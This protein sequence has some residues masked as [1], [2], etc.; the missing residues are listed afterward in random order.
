MLHALNVKFK[1]ETALKLGFGKFLVPNTAS[2]LFF[3]WSSVYH[4]S[5]PFPLSISVS[6]EAYLG[7]RHGA[8][9]G[10][11]CRPVLSRLPRRHGRPLQRR[12]L[13]GQLPVRPRPRR[14]PQTGVHSGGD[15][16]PAGPLVGRSRGVGDGL[17]PRTLH[18]S[19]LAVQQGS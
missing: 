11:G 17:G 6:S 15:G 12:P 4:N 13:S 16:A 19:H 18:G 3:S 1:S 5:F 9:A 7:H 14:R 8:G 10:T 2:F